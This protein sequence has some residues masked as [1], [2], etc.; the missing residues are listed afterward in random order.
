M[1]Y[2]SVA[3]VGD[4]RTKNLM[5]LELNALSPSRLKYIPASS[6]HDNQSNMSCKLHY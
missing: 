2:E 5:R 6:H 1:Y 4:K 3:L